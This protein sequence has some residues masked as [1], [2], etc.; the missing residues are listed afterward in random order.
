VSATVAWQATVLALG[1]VVVGVPCGVA[2]G[3]WT[4]HLVAREVGSV[5]PPVVPVVGVLLVVP[6]TLLAANVLA[7][8]PAWSAGRIRPADVLHNE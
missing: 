2:L 1:A 6:I 3:R 5:A 8:A 4:W 7:G